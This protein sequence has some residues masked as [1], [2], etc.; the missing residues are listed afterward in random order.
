MKHITSC[1]FLFLISISFGLSQNVR[2][3][4]TIKDK[5]GIPLTGAHIVLDGTNQGSSADNNGFY[6][7][8]RIKPGQYSIKVSYVGYNI[9]KRTVQ[10]TDSLT[11]VDFLLEEAAYLADEA[12]ITATGNKVARKDVLPA[13][14]IV[15]RETLEERDLSHLDDLSMG[16]QKVNEIV[17]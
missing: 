15:S 9:E 2:M 16:Y 12:V 4:G 10:L 17:E 5:S 7:I 3:E 8:S 13:I 1:F 6:S 14:S 11:I